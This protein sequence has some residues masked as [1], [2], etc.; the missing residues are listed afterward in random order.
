[1]AEKFPST[2]TTANPS[3]VA[4]LK[5]VQVK[6]GE[7]VKL[8][9]SWAINIDASNN[10][11]TGTWI[12]ISGEPDYFCEYNPPFAKANLTGSE[13]AVAPRLWNALPLSLQEKTKAVIITLV[14]VLVTLMI[15]SSCCIIYKRRIS[16]S[17]SYLSVKSLPVVPVSVLVVYPAENSAFQHAVVAL[18][19]FLQLH[20]GCSVAIDV[21]QQGKIAGLGPLRWLVE[22]EKAADYV[23]IVSPQG[24]TRSSLLSQSTA[25]HN[26]PEHSIPAAAR[27]LYPLILNM[28]ASHAKN[29]SQ[30]SRFWVVHLN[31]KPSIILPEL[32]VRKSFCLMKDLDKLC[33]SL[34][35]PRKFGKKIS[36]LLFKPGV[37]Y[38]K[39]ST[40][41]KEAIEMLER[42]Q[43]KLIQRNPDWR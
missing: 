32:K 15:L 26:L 22:Q 7:E 19:E 24:E 40:K 10:Y 17:A 2:S 30:L 37:F 36:S 9:I 38:S 1:M 6:K 33:E 31:K 35:A 42:V 3:K 25:N 34:H 4:D 12:T 21:W 43:I 14:G 18:A 39:N 8:N 5:V 41:L 13:Q 27:D 11:L 28:V 29:A 16:T 20:G 23:L